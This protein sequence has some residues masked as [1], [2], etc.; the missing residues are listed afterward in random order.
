LHT[1]ELLGSLAIALPDWGINI[2]YELWS[3]FMIIVD[4][5]IMHDKTILLIGTW[6]TTRENSATTRVEWDALGWLMRKAS[7]GW[8]YPKGAS[9]EWID[10]EYREVLGSNCLW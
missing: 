3:W 9:R 5:I 8:P 1:N 6:R 7:E 10:V 2:I 4:F